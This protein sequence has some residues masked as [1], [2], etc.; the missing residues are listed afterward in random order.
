MT[1]R[2]AYGQKLYVVIYFDRRIAIMAQLDESEEPKYV[3]P[4]TF[5]NDEDLQQMDE[6]EIREA[7]EIKLNFWVRLAEDT[8]SIAKKKEAEQEQ[9]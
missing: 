9:I 6:K 2:L 5:V 8:I 4:I 7:A 1:K 3:K